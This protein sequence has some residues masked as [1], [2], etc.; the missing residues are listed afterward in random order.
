MT[1]E[2]I[3]AM[4]E[5]LKKA[6]EEHNRLLEE[7]ELEDTCWSGYQDS[8]IVQLF[9]QVT[10]KLEKETWECDFTNEPFMR[11]LDRV[12]K[13]KAEG[14]S[15]E[16]MDGKT[17]VFPKKGEIFKYVNLTGDLANLYI[18]FEDDNK[19]LWKMLSYIFVEEIFEMIQK[20]KSKEEVNH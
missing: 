2:G 4:K 5:L 20:S 13:V 14:F 1:E 17:T 15:I 18:V 6:E 10:V 16:S 12:Y 11:K 7:A 19:C 9:H 8:S 3:K